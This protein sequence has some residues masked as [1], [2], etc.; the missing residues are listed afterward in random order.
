MDPLPLDPIFVS[1][2]CELYSVSPSTILDIKKAFDIIDTN[3]SGAIQPFEFQSILEERGLMDE[4][5]ISTKALINE[6]DSNKNGVID[7][8]EFLKFSL[9]KIDEKAEIEEIES[10]FQYYDEE[11]KGKIDV[12]DLKKVAGILGQKMTEDEVKKMLNLLDNDGDGFVEK[13]DFLD[14]MMGKTKILG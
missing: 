1:K 5:G 7:F 10:V 4:T 2:S 3:K 8:E 13:E 12:N 11:N 9:K 6:L 14:M